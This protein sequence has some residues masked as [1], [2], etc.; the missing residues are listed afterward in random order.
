MVT[1][2]IYE[3][4]THKVLKINGRLDAL[5]AADFENKLNEAIEGHNGHLVFDLSEVDYISSAGIRI[6]LMLINK[7]E[8]S[9][10]KIAVAGLNEMLREVFEISGIDMYIGIFDS[11]EDAL[12]TLE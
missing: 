3:R 2:T 9:A 5:N 1:I 10:N 8:G 11:I 12:N 4:H 7:M 6:F